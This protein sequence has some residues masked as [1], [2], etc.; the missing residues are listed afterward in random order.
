[1]IDQ[2]R[3][4]AE[5][6]R[7]LERLLRHSCTRVVLIGG[8]A[9]DLIATETDYDGEDQ[10]LAVV[11]DA[12]SLRAALDAVRSGAAMEEIDG[13]PDRATPTPTTEAPGE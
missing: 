1:M 3:E 7:A 4:D 6:F 2:D 8:P 12:N 13:T 11:E 9:I 5:R 10:Y